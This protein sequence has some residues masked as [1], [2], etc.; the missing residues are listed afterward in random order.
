MNSFLALSMATDKLTKQQ[1]VTALKIFR[2]GRQEI[3]PK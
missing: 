3:E 1:Q 2:T